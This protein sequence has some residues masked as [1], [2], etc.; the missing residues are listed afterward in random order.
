MP[1]RKILVVDDDKRLRDLLQRYLTEQGFVVR[2]AD[3]A[4]AM[5]KSL[6][7][8]TFDL[9]VLDL[10]LP[11]EDGLS[12]CRRLRTSEPQQAIIMLTAKGDEID[13]IVGLEMGADDYLPKPFNPR[14]LVARIQAVLRRQTKVVPGAPTAEDKTITFG[15]VEVDLATRTLKR[16]AEMLPLTTGEFAV[17]RVML[18]HPRQPL[19]R[20]RLMTLA[21]GRE[22]G[23][24]DRAIDVQISRLR[25]LVE[26]DPTVPRYLQTVWGFGYVFIPDGHGQT[27]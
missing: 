15:D 5:D 24:F 17:L 3:N 26:P 2:T 20:D 4:D 11:G 23:P 16:N 13:R 19:S 12:I 25:K 10:M 9:I 14:E 27:T 18:E 21:R 6:T 8:D 7:R 1:E 22:Q